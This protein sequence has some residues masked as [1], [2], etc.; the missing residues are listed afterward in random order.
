M[1]E[2]VRV[3]K[4]RQE[5]ALVEY[6][7]D[8]LLGDDSSLEWFLHSFGH[9]LHCVNPA[10]FLVFYLP[11]LPKAPAADDTNVVEVAFSDFLPSFMGGLKSEPIFNPIAEANLLV[12]LQTVD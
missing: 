5:V 10:Y 1:I 3:L 9:L 6:G 4:L 7:R 12:R 8:A 2:A 11:D